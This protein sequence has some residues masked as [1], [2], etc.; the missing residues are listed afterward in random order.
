MTKKK[1]V[2]KSRSSS[3]KRSVPISGVKTIMDMIKYPFNKFSR[4][5]NFYWVLL[6]ILGWLALA[7]YTI[8]IVQA[9]LK[10]DFKELPA[11]G[12]FTENMKKGFFLLV[13]MIPIFVVIGLLN[14]VPFIGPIAIFLLGLFLLPMLYLQYCKNENFMEGYQVKSAI[15]IV[16]NNIW[17]YILMILK[18]LLVGVVFV[19]ASVFI[20]TLIV[21][22]PAL[23]FSKQF[24]I[25][26]FYNRN[27]K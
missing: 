26:D 14:L 18:S 23:V 21:T 3:I 12:G 11:F 5:F 25:V 27:S 19:V 4:L 22:L 17:D 7:G 9:M 13:Y 10:K 2:K 8:K 16:F 20:I 6:P 15:N 1:T 24:L